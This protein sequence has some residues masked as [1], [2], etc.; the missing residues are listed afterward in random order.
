MA[1]HVGTLRR[2]AKAC[3]AAL[4]GACLLPAAATELVYTPVNPNFGGSPLNGPALLG[5][6]QATNRHKDPAAVDSAALFAKQTPLQQFTDMLER[7]VLGQLSAAAT[8]GVMGSGGK[9]KPGTVETG[10]FR[11]DIVDAGG[12]VLIIT[13]TDKVTGQTS[14]FQIGGQGQ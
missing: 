12:G 8:A 9:L 1:H 5:T 10:N 6:A 3:L 11:I 7:S 14:T 13:T 4:A 2:A